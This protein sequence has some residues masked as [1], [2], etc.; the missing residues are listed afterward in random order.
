MNRWRALS[1]L[2]AGCVAVATIGAALAPY[3]VVP[4]ILNNLLVQMATG[5]VGLCL[6]LLVRR[7]VRPALLTALALAGQAV[8]LAPG[9][10][11]GEFGA[12]A[13]ARSDATLRLT[14]HNVLYANTAYTRT[15]DFL[16]QN[17]ADVVILME[18]APHWSAALD[19]LD[20]L[21]PYRVSCPA[22]RACGF[23]L[24]S[25]IPLRDA[26]A[27][28]ADDGR[29]RVVDAVITV[30]GRALRIV[31]THLSTGLSSRQY[32]LQNRQL[33]SLLARL[34]DMDTPTILAGDFNM[35]PWT[36]RLRRF[37]NQADL[38]IAPGLDG[39]WPAM[40]P[41]PARIPIDHVMTSAHLLVLDRT[42]GPDLGS[43]HRP[44]TVTVGFDDL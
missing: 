38:A 5:A 30:R 16:R 24:L 22:R 29:T 40:L 15:L 31:D 2:A 41:L 7:H 12:S 21:Y 23:T 17:Q 10:G 25:R 3:G 11:L 20:D 35:A 27:G 6:L 37:A 28:W 14:T 8:L 4:S 36:P 1:W 13:N 26:W 19:T 18:V 32:A 42:V 34:D 39:T 9:A 44:V 33:R 43:D